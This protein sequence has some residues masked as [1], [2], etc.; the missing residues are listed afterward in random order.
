VILFCTFDAAKLA[1]VPVHT[2]GLRE[3]GFAALTARD[4]ALSRS[5]VVFPRAIVAAET[6]KPPVE[7]MRENGVG[8][9]AE[10]THEH[11]KRVLAHG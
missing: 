6:T 3:Y 9:L 8:P 5:R 2:R 10:A 7:L 11:E 4:P 1:F